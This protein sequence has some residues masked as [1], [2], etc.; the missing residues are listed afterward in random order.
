LKSL[1]LACEKLG[2]KYGRFTDGGLIFH[3]TRHTFVSSLLADD[4]DLETTRELAGL[5][6]RNGP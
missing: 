3:D 6:E 1:K 4:I 2:I 5:I